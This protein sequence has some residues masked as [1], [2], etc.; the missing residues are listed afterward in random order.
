MKRKKP[1]ANIEAIMAR[2]VQLAA[3][4]MKN[5]SIKRVLYIEFGINARFHEINE[6]TEDV[7]QERYDAG[8]CRRFNLVL[9]PG[10]YDY[11]A[12]GASRLPFAHMQSPGVIEREPW[13]VY[14]GPVIRGERP[15]RV[16][17]EKG[18][19]FVIWAPS[20]AGFIEGLRRMGIIAT[21]YDPDE[22][23]CEQVELFE[24]RMAA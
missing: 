16:M 22:S 6:W 4:G 14:R 23:K 24:R 19:P 13:R 1:L 8:N 2:A 12:P 11:D 18:D 9:F 15:Y 7:R 3:S 10:E 21:P 20:L 5:P 17:P